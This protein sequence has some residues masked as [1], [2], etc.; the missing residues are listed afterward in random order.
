MTDITCPTNISPERVARRTAKLNK[1]RDTDFPLWASAGETVLQQVAGPKNTAEQIEEEMRVS[2]LDYETRRAT[3]HVTQGYKAYLYRERIRPF[4]TPTAFASLDRKR[5][6][7][8]L[9]PTY[10]VEYWQGLYR[11]LSLPTDRAL[12]LLGLS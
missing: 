12:D 11:E 6:I 9:D 7:Y 5:R 1:K 2:M 10:A 3:L 4:F 8:P